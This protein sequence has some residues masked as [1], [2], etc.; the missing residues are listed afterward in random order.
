MAAHVVKVPLVI[1]KSVEGTDI[2]LYEG[3]RVPQLRAGE[4]ARLEEYIEPLPDVPSAEELEAQQRAANEAAAAA[5]QERFNAAVTAAVD[6][7]LAEQQAA[8]TPK[9][10]PKQP[11][12]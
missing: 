9:T 2:Y 5:E 8:E 1:A 3:M 7:R 6:A 11:T 4:L 12:K 10:A